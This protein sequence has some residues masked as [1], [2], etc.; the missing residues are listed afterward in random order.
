MTLCFACGGSSIDLP[1][2]PLEQE[3]DAIAEMYEAPTGTLD[4][5]E[6]EASVAVVNERMAEL[7][8]EGLAE[9]ILRALVNLRTRLSA[10]SV[11]A[12]PNAPE[13]SDRAVIDAVIR[14]HQTCRGFHDAPDGPDPA[15]N[16]SVEITAVIDDSVL[17]RELW[18]VATACRTASEINESGRVR[19][20]ADLVLDGTLIVYLYGP[21]PENREE[22]GFLV[23]FTGELGRLGQP[24]SLDFDFR[25]LNG[26]LEFRH[27]VEGGDIIVGIEPEA[28]SLRGVNTTVTCDFSTLECAQ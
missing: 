23:R 6:L 16:G 19:V 25:F 12:D 11:P 14:L 21:L 20:A 7:H 8:L 15:T 26:V 3:T 28:F 27:P 13:D 22:A 4:V 9:I 24:R 17:R 1:D 18:G 5:A 2:P 10:S